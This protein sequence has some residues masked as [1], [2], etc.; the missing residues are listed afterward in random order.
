M[1]TSLFIH[2]LYLKSSIE[3]AAV[4][5]QS[6]DA[7]IRYISTTEYWTQF[8][9]SSIALATIL[10]A[11]KDKQFQEKLLRI[12]KLSN[13]EDLFSAID[14]FQTIARPET[15]AILNSTTTSPQSDV[16]M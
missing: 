5:K 14:I 16:S 13:E 8:L 2:T 4:L 9:P 7:F 10:L 3:T 1:I 11:T 12:G 15:K 6:C